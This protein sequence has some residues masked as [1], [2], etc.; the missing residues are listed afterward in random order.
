MTTHLKFKI[1]LEVITA[2]TEKD[3]SIFTSDGI[4]L[5]VL[6]EMLNIN[7]LFRSVFEIETLSANLLGLKYYMTFI[8]HIL[9]VYLFTLPVV[10]E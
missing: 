8:A 1:K 7:L 9:F 10:L 4:F 5:S 6:Q 3:K 2:I